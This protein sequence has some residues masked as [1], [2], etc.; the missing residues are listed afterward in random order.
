M[1][2]TVNSGSFAAISFQKYGGLINGFGRL[3]GYSLVLV[4]YIS[5]GKLWQFNRFG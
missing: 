4:H 5:T 3:N 2:V 1:D